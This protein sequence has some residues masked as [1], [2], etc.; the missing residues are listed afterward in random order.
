[1]PIG[2][3]DDHLKDRKNVLEKIDIALN[4]IGIVEDAFEA[5]EHA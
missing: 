5:P 2:F 3:R 4:D 1:M